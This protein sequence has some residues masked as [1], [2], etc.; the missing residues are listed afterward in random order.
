MTAR[1]EGG[2]GAAPFRVSTVVDAGCMSGRL[3]CPW[4][5]VVLLRVLL[6]VLLDEGVHHIAVRFVVALGDDLPFLAVPLLDRD[7]AGPFVVRAGDLDR[8]GEALETELRV[9]LLPRDPYADK[10]VILEIRAGAGGDEASLFAQD[11]LRMYSR[12]AEANGWK[13]E[14]MN[15]SFSPIG[16]IKEVTAGVRGRGVYS[17]MKYESRLPRRGKDKETAHMF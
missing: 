3:A 14:I 4:R 10:S 7:L 5:D 8:N 15:T 1:T 16:G 12:Y 6:G 13:I 11:L 9:M 17:R 2:V